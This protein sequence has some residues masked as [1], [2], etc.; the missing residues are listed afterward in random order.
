MVN[1]RRLKFGNYCLQFYRPRS[2]AVSV[3]RSD[4]VCI[5]LVAHKGDLDRKKSF[6]SG[7]VEASDLING[8]SPG[9]MSFYYE[10]VR[11]DG[12]SAYA[13]F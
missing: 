6:L 7:V 3:G 8:E 13:N 12:E 11:D 9:P 5:S 4:L 1:V 10:K 2:R